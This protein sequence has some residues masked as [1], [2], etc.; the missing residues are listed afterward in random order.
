MTVRSVLLDIAGVIWDGD[1]LIPGAVE[2]VA[3]LRAA[4]LPFRLVTNTTRRPKRALI[5]QLQEFGFDMTPGDVFTGTEA[6]V[7]YLRSRNLTPYLL[8]HPALDSEFADLVGETPN[9]VVVGDAADRFTYGRL[10]AAFRLLLVGAPLLA[11]ASNRYFKDFDGLSL[12]AGPFIAALEY[13]AQVEANVFG[14]PAP[15]FFDA[16]LADLGAAPDETVMIGDDVEADVNGALAVGLQ[17]ILVR[18]GKY[19]AGDELRMNAGGKS[20]ATVREAVTIVLAGS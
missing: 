8:V 6:V 16:V 17:A 7:E 18:T 15:A 13:A 20:A 10:N 1:R 14:K 2:A 12:D 9:A 5:E 4:N 3:E 19:R 11:I